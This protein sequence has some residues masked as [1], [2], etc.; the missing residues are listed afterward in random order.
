MKMTL[1]VLGALGLTLALR[2]RSAALRHWVLAAGIGCGAAVP[3]LASVV[4]SWSVP[5]ATPA[6]FVSIEEPEAA[7][8]APAVGAGSTRQPATGPA[9]PTP[10]PAPSGGGRNAWDTVERVW[11]VGAAA[12]LAVLL[13]GALRLA[14]LASHAQP[15]VRGR[16]RQIADEI[17]CQYGLRRPVTILQSEHPTLLVTWGLAR[18][19]VILPS[20]AE[21]WTDDRARVVLSHELAHICRGDWIV[22]LAAEL[23][24]A[25]YWFNPIVWIACRRL[26]LESEHACDDE[27]MVRGIAGTDYASHLIDLARALNHRR[28]LWLPAPAMARPSSLERRVRAML[29]DRLEREPVSGATRALIFVMVLAAAAAVAAAQTAYMS[30]SGVVNDEQGRGIPGTAVVLSNDVRQ[31]KYEIKTTNDG[32]FEFV[33][34]PAGD[35]RVQVEGIGFQSLRDALTIEGKNVQRNFTLM[36]GTLQETIMVRFDPNAAADAEAA[37][38][39][40]VHEV[41]MPAPKECV[42]STA[43]GRIVPPKK[44][45]SVNPQYP[46]SL[47]GSGVEGTVVMRGRIAVDGYISDISVVQEAHPELAQAAIAA[48]RQWRFTETLL[49]CRPAEPMMTITTK[50]ERHVAPPPPPAPPRP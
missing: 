10:R 39:P 27:V 6:A 3:F 2:Q 13:I 46:P 42:A 22:Q 7:A 47:R 28:H 49:N 40:S 11:W 30:F 18:P 33:G 9:A 19:K 12:S 36:L 15:L 26:R 25:V 41:P 31:A 43:G 50:F 8:V 45:R 14:W 38:P 17:A 4:P 44:I 16:W 20:A 37:K 1:V 32:R 5:L 34:L 35:Y 21:M 23:L 48:V 24:R 29:N